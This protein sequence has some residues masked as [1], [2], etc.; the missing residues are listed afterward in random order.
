MGQQKISNQSEYTTTYKEKHG[1][2]GDGL[3]TANKMRGK[4]FTSITKS[5]TDLCG[6]I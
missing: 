3:Q 6:V 4:L 2:H 1:T 5:V